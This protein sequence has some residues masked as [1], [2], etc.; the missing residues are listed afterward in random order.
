[1]YFV[2]LIF[3]SG[4]GGDGEDLETSVFIRRSVYGR[5]WLSLTRAVGPGRGKQ[6]FLELV[7]VCGD[8]LPGIPLA[9]VR[10]K[11]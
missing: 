6:A 1:M 5:V 11:A 3:N 2:S 9:S 8:M 10:E 7:A 4:L